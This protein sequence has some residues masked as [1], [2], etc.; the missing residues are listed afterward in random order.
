MRDVTDGTSNT[1]LLGELSWNNANCYRSWV[2]GGAGDA[3][4]TSKNVVYGINVQ[5]SKYNNSNLFNDV[6]FGSQHPGGCQ[7]AMADGSVTFVQ[8]SI[9]MDVYKATASCDGNEAKTIMNQ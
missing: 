6:S 2:R 3:I 8:E 9:N 1:F 7:F 4:P 5:T